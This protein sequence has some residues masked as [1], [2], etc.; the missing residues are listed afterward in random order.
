[1]GT[2]SSSPPHWCAPTQVDKENCFFDKYY[3]TFGPKLRTIGMGRHRR[4]IKSDGVYEICMRTKVGL[5]FVCTNYMKL[6]IE[7]IISRVQRD[8]KVV[9][10]HMNF[11]G[12]HP[13]MMVVAKDSLECT[14]FYGEIKKQLT[15]AIKNLSGKDNLSLWQ[16]NGTSVSHYGDVAGVV[17]RIAYIYANPA[18]AHLVDSIERYPGLSSWEAYQQTP[19]TLLAKHKKLCPWIRLPAISKLPSRSMSDSQDKFF[20][21]RL[22]HCSKKKHELIYHPNAWMLSFDVSEQE[23]Q[24]INENILNRLRGMEQEKRNERVNK[25]FRVKGANKLKAEALNLTYRSK[26]R[27]IKIFAYALDPVIRKKLIEE[28]KLF[29]DECDE[30]YKRW[31]VGDYLVQWPPGAFLPPMPPRINWF[32]E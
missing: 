1:M 23:V 18:N 3:E 20:T 31:K 29:C 6:I 27:S 7:G 13:H 25:G 26:N 19:N 11:M 4:Q 32:D 8:S 21:T 10:C 17:E 30:C 16:K 5:P 28:Y 12:N 9:L 15:D 14:R 2:E 22:K 24:S